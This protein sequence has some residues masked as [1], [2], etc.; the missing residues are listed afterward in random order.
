MFLV[1]YDQ[2]N[3]GLIT[4]YL[5]SSAPNIPAATR[6]KLLNDAF[7]L[8]SNG[9]LNYIAALNMTMLLFSETDYSVWMLFF[10]RISELQQQCLWTP[11]EGK[12]NVRDIIHL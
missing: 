12:L 7:L 8:A 9:E 5:V 1:N 2:Q 11:I 6:K 4:Q 3:W 10:K